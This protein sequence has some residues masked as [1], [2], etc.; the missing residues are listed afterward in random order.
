MKKYLVLDIGTYRIKM[1]YGSYANGY[2][3]AERTATALSPE[4]IINNGLVDVDI[5]TKTIKYLLDTLD[6]KSHLA[7]VSVIE[8]ST[9][10]SRS[11]TMPYLSPEDLNSM[12]H[13]EIQRLFADVLQ[14]Y[15]V[16]YTCLNVYDN[17]ETGGKQASVM[18]F[19][20]P[21]NV[22]QSYY[23][24]FGKCGVEQS[25]LDILPN[26]TSRIL[27]QR[28]F[29]NDDL[30]S[31]SDTYAFIDIG[32]MSTSI[33]IVSKGVLAF[34]R[35]LQ[36]GGNNITQ[37]IAEAMNID[38]D[39]A[40]KMKIASADMNADNVLNNQVVMEIE[41][42]IGEIQRV[43][44]YYLSSKGSSGNIDKIFIYGGTSRIAGLDDYMS[45][46]LN[47][48]V[49][50]IDKLDFINL[51]HELPLDCVQSDF[52]NAASALMRI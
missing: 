19:A 6:L 29:I 5:A 24:L 1:L 49:K 28:V 34:T 50:R 33:I 36:R 25:V 16:D 30:C 11:L 43:F 4:G 39:S 27:R 32:H 10:V 8:S 21:E 47:I 41:D 23:D 7:G 18:V 48:P 2:V 37:S 13:M 46:N 42:I 20:I 44:R 14:N 40:D 12:V 22:F 31:P 45:Q 38:Y 9:V 52:L 35:T 17:E 26:S 3:V 15:M 51:K